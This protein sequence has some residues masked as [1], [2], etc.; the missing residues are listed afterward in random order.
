MGREAEDR[1]RTRVG[2]RLTRRRLL[3][4]GAG[5]VV[6]AGVA[7]WR[8][9]GYP[10]AHV[11]RSLVALGAS[12]AAIVGAL[13]EVVLPPGSDRSPAVVRAHVRRVDAYV[14]G[15]SE[16]SRRELRAL[17]HCLEHT[18]FWFGGGVRR[19]SRLP[20]G[21]REAVLRGWLGSRFEV[22][23]V[24]ARGLV[25]LVFLAH[26]VDDAAFRRIGYT[27]PVARGWEG[28]PAAAARYAAL[29][30][31]PGVSPSFSAGGG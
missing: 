10:A 19:F 9:G 3:R 20:S 4:L 12:G 14:G 6:L 28:P 18:A 2:G 29:L 13:V 11:P 30:A 15:L 25:A 16:R 26:Y 27:G 8:F 1:G 31:P 23:R 22:P 24:A 21:A 5:G 7:G 17:L